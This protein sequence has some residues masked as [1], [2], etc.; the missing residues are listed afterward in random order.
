MALPKLTVVVKAIIFPLVK[1]RRGSSG[2]RQMMLW[3]NTD[4]FGPEEESDDL[5]MRR[6]NQLSSSWIAFPTFKG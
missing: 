5:R 6:N 4:A 2:G 1:G 3:S